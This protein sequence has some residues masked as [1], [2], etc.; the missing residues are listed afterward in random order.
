MLRRGGGRRSRSRRRRGRNDTRHLALP[1][2][3]IRASA[4]RRCNSPYRGR[5][6]RRGVVVA[7]DCSSETW[8]PIAPPRPGPPPPPDAGEN[9][10]TAAEL[11][12]GFGNPGREGGH[13]RR[14]QSSLRL[15]A[16]L[17]VCFVPVVT[18]SPPAA[19][20]SP[21]LVCFCGGEGNGYGR[22]SGPE[23]VRTTHWSTGQYSFAGPNC[24]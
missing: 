4:T 11:G 18:T 7:L 8:R 16:I 23:R 3:S 13:W 5:S 20:A 17:L 21:S 1:L 15:A 22:A 24:Q 6:A 2:P 9:P 19:S 12:L 14:S 10:R